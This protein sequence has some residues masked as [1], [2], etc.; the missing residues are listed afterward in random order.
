MMARITPSGS[1]TK[2]ARTVALVCA[3]S[4]NAKFERIF[5]DLAKSGADKSCLIPPISAAGAALRVHALI[6]NR[7]HTREFRSILRDVRKLRDWMV[8][9]GEF[10][11]SGDFISGQ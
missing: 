9:R 11:L 5:V 3:L 7:A 4:A 1:M 10:E 2:V 6:G 8:E